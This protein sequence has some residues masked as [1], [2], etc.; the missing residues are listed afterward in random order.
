MNEEFDNLRDVNVKKTTNTAKRPIGILRHNAELM[1]DRGAP[2]K[3][4]EDYLWDNGA[5]MD[6]IMA[7]PSPNDDELARMIESEKSGEWAKLHQQGIEATKR[8]EA[9][10]KKLET[11]QGIQ[12][13]VR[14]F[15]NGLLLNYGDELES[16]LTG[17][18]VDQIRQEQSDWSRKNPT[19]D[20]A[21]GIAGGMAPTLAGFGAGGATMGKT[22]LTRML[23]GAGTGAG[24]GAVA[25]YGAGTGD[26][27]NRL[28]TAGYGSLF[29]GGIGAAAPLALGGIGRATG[30]IARGMGKGPSEKEVGNFMLN[31]VVAEAGRPGAG[32]QNNAS[33]LFQAVQDGDASIQN[34]ARNLQNKMLAMS[35]QRN[36]EIV[37]LA[38][39]PNWTAET[40]SAQ[41]IMRALTTDSKRAASEKF[42][43]FVAQQPDKTGLGLAL[44]EYF[45]KN[46]IAKDI[47]LANKRRIGEDLTTYEGLQKIEDVLNRN[48]PK[49]LDNSRVVNR[50]AQI[51]DAIE[52]LSNL[53]EVAFPGQK[54]MDAT[55][56]ASVGGVNDTAQKTAKSYMSQLASGVANPTNL[57]VS[58]TGASKFGLK[59]YVRGRAR[60]LIKRGV[61]DPDRTS[62]GEQLLQSLGFGGYRTLEQ[63]R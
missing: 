54:V 1:R 36:P 27:S 20:L 19:L 29:G 25:G 15:G 58:L 21:L 18:D 4:I 3:D 33:V 39:N 26:W 12:G 53:R 50:N 31:N 30:R 61:L 40:P 10:R 13:G 9:N 62:F 22:A 44:N 45:K 17:Q 16:Y 5:D 34:A 32:A 49:S 23:M 43:E 48:L 7:V 47:V 28:E 52:D 24:L 41:N 55:Y 59:P 8:A 46:P 14:S 56:R 60:E 37:E 63:Q 6:L 2:L 42:G 38:L 57:E 11:L 51:L 35:A